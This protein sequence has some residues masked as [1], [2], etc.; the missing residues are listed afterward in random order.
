MNGDQMDLLGGEVTKKSTRRRDRGI[1]ASAQHAERSAPGW[2]DQAL[3]QLKRYLKTRKQAP[4][5]TEDF[6][7][8]IR[9][10]IKDPPDGRAWG[11]VMRA[12]AARKL[13]KKI[14]YAPAETSNF[15][16]KVQWQGIR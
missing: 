3:E 15:S 13:V 8:W 1:K 2:R 6:V 10:R 7:L 5:L 9:F 11:N 14:G 4:F 12:A 16:P